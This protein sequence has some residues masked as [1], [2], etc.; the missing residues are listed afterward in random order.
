[1]YIFYKN[2]LEFILDTSVSTEYL[3]RKGKVL[4][5]GMFMTIP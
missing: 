4:R 1:M 5:G 3:S 2:S